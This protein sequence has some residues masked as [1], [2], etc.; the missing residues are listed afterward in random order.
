[1]N[2]VLATAL[3]WTENGDL[4]AIATVVKTWGSAPRQ[5]GSQIVVRKDGA[6]EGSVS[7]GCVEGAVIEEALAAIASGE[8]MTLNYGV[9]DE[10]AWSLGLPCGGKI[11]I[12][13]EPLSAARRN[14][15]VAIHA[16]TQT[17]QPVVLA[18]SLSGESDRL[19]DP[20]R[21]QSELGRAALEAARRDTSAPIELGGKTWFLAVHNP[22]LDLV[23]VGAVHI[24]Q[25]LVQMARMAGYQVRVI[26]PRPSFANEVRFPGA[27]L[28]R[29]WPDEALGAQPLGS[30][31]AFIALAHDP[32]LD[33]PG[34]VAA[35]RSNCFYVGA[36]GSKKNQA[37]R[38]QR[39]KQAGLS[40]A[41]LD[42][43]HGPVGLPIG[44]RSPA[45]I[46]ISIMAEMTQVLRK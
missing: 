37:A 13:V 24:A 41:Q 16:A 2:D 12:Y 21:D 31:S 27:I 23:I 39:L 6:F 46:A 15:L 33:D 44:A 4:V 9:S 17:R 25:V 43:L 45:E 10:T 1:M 26:D 5:A 35:L 11:E 7:G 28:V 40:D 29:D 8:N 20:Y 32:K 19:I 3:R 36:L 30:R 18:I 38:L 42:R 22:P 14:A 34:L